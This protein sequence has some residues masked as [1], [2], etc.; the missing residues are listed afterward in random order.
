MVDVVDGAA[1]IIR[2]YLLPAIW[3][4]NAASEVGEASAPAREEDED[5]SIEKGGGGG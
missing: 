4:E 1:R 2:L 5:G 3:F